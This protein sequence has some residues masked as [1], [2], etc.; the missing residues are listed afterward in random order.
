MS[1]IRD[2]QDAIRNLA[3]DITDA[4]CG[5]DVHYNDCGSAAVGIAAFRMVDGETQ[6]LWI[7]H[8]HDW[9]LE[10]AYLPK[11]R[12]LRH[13]LEELQKEAL[14]EREKVAA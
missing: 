4:N 12:L 10:E 14:G 11:L 1:T 5:L 3:R 6:T 7:E 13:K 8:L 2:E 9:D